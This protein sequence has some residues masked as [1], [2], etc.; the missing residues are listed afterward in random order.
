MEVRRIALL[1]ALLDAQ[2]AALEDPVRFL[3][4]DRE[5]HVAIYQASTNRLLADFCT[6]LYT[7]MMEYR[8]RAM[9]LPDAIAVS[10]ADHVAIVEKLRSR[11]SE[12]AAEVFAVH[13]GRIYTTTQILMRGES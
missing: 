6:D 5:F 7:Y 3:I 11:D 10:Y 13:T 4:C 1:D 9:S 2:K 12:A 8:R